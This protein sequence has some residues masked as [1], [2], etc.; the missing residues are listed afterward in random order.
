MKRIAFVVNTS[1]HIYNF[2]LGLIKAFQRQG[3]EV[4]AISPK[5]DFTQKLIDNNI[6]HYDIEINNIGTNPVEDAKLTH[7]YYKLYKEI[8]P[9]LVMH[10]TAKPN[11]YGSIAA[12][13]LG[14]P[15]ISSITGLGTIFLHS[16]LA[17][18][19]AKM[20]YKVA[21]KMPKK[22]FFENPNDRDLFVN[23]GFADEEKTVRA[24]GWGIDTEYL[25]PASIDAA[26]GENRQIR[27]LFVA[28]LIKDKGLMEYIDA[29]RL[30]KEKYKNAKFSILGSFYPENPTAISEK[31]MDAWVKEGVVE[32]LGT[33]EDVKSVIE[34]QD[35]IVLPSYR[36]GLSRV[37]LEAAS[38][39]KPIVTTNVPGCKEVVEDGVTGFLCNKKDA[40][41]L[42]RK[43]EQ[44]ILLKDE[45]RIEMGAKARQ[46]IIQEFDEKLVVS[47][48]LSVVNK[49]FRES[50]ST[51]SIFLETARSYR[52]ALQWMV[53]RPG[54]SSTQSV[55]LDL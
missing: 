3:Y 5:D 25:K 22:V 4:V 15:S 8:K 28:R 54:I 27:F 47:L 2:R 16:S 11:I 6:K 23:H 44:V 36:E 12:K 45:Q 20:M 41:D 38:M 18:K 9:D 17:L 39:A 24:P 1:W 33:T 14:I 26:P 34:R 55:S 30:L 40:F 13:M 43:I 32:Y 52:E 19:V 51:E 37:L 46:K 48:Y 53:Q 29:I 42:A 10:F 21:L 31:T 7:D 50:V 49:L 35:C